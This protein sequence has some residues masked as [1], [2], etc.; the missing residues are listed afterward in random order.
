MLA[1][2]PELE[3][4]T[5]D[6]IAECL[7]PLQETSLYVKLWQ[8]IKESSNPTPLGGD[9]SNGT[10]EYPCGRLN[11]HNDKALHW[12]SKLDD[13]DRQIIIDAAIKDGVVEPNKTW[14]TLPFGR[15]AR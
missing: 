3:L 5:A 14:G 12:W 6:E 9:G 15:A 8:F 7:V 11:P 10:V 13:N 2:P 4:W 1:L